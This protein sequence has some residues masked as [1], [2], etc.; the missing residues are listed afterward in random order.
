LCSNLEKIEFNGLAVDA[1]DLV[2]DSFGILTIGEGSKRG[3]VWVDCKL[4]VDTTGVG[5]VALTKLEV[6]VVEVE[7]FIGL[8]FFEKVGTVG[9]AVVL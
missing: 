8:K 3:G 7:A 6:K 5:A 4:G 2:S 9:M 1:F